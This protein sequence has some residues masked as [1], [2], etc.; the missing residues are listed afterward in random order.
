MEWWVVVPGLLSAALVVALL[1]WVCMAI[2]LELG[3]GNL[4]AAWQG[5]I[6]AWGA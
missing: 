4:A 1:V 6:D 5:L 2:E 3:E